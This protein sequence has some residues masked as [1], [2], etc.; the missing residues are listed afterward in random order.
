MKMNKRK[1][2]FLIVVIVLA[3]IIGIYFFIKYQT[4]NYMQ[5]VQNYENVST[6]NANYRVCLDGVLRYSRDGVALLAKDGADIWNQACQM[7]NPVVEMCGDS[8]AV[9]D[10]G[11]T[12]ILV[13][14]KKGL[15]GEI[16]TTRPIEKFSVSSQGIVSAILKDEEVPLVMCYDA[17]GN[18]LVKHEVSLNTMGYPTDVAISED[19]NTLLVSY[20]CTEGNEIISKIVYYY[21]GAGATE[22]DDYQVLQTEFHDMVIPTTA[23]L[24]D[25][26]SLLV[27]DKALVLYKGLNQPKEF[28]RIELEH[29]IQSVAYSKEM[30]AILL[31]NDGTDGYQLVIYNIKGKQLASVAV[32]KEYANITIAEGQ[33]IMHDGQLCSIYMKNGIHKFDGKMDATILEIFPIT[34]L[35][36]YM[37]INASG[38]QE[39][40][41]V[42]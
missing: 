3:A 39:V 27:A 15:K 7:S 28:I 19:G 42:Q 6:D 24:D 22:E 14:Q 36:K 10:K 2:L 30:I 40:K 17:K 11:G 21:F 20:L 4:Y 32:D 38:F 5:V 33:I 18:V 8:F 26:I 35:N 31:K 25:D 1:V 41:L 37:V 9:G 34:G 13:F 29:E 12:S 16:K 23:F